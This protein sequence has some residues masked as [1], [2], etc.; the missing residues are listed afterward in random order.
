M[1]PPLV[2]NEWELISLNGVSVSLNLVDEGSIG[3]LG[4][5]NSLQLEVASEESPGQAPFAA[6]QR[7]KILDV[8]FGP[9]KLLSIYL[10]TRCANGSNASVRPLPFA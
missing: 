10:R 2:C 5:L 6:I 9:P 7:S 1:N 8:R 4:A 3:I